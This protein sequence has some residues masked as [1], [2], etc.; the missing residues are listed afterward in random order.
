MTELRSAPDPAPTR[1]AWLPRLLRET[2]FRR[3]FA[4]QA[5]SQFG[6]QV[7]YLALP[8]MAVL[9]IGAGPA[10]M[11]YLTAA[12][13]IPN[14]LFSLHA[15][16]WVDRRPGKRQVM[17]VADLGRAVLL[18]AVPVLWWAG[19]LDLPHL[20]VIAFAIGTLSLFFE[21]AHGSLF[22]SLVARPDYIDANALINGTRAMSY[23]AG[24]SIGGVLVQVLTAPFALL[25]DVF[26]YLV[27]ALLLRRTTV[28]ERPVTP[29][30]SPGLG[31]GLRY[32]A[33]S[34]V[35][36]SILL[37]V[38]TLNLFNYIFAA[39]FVLYVTTQLGVSPGTLGAVIG[40]GAVGGL[41]GA[42]LTGRLSRRIG[43]GPTV[44]VGMVAF[45][46]PLVL[47]PA[48]EGSRP[49]VLGMLFAAEFCSALGVMVL[50]IAVGSLQTAATPPG[51]LALVHGAKRTVNYGVRPIGALIGGALGTALGVRPALWI[52]TVGALAGTLW[53]LFSPVRRMRELPPEP[54]EPAR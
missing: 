13:L 19:L 53:I 23:V 40:A 32:I 7:T 31:A 28:T 2:V 22:A 42:A 25:A 49:V 29:E 39:L 51:M 6:D 10:E 43:I 52:A 1:R 9:A 21:V 34:Q 54:D 5:V 4:A 45:P 14:L 18:A 24:P 26:S 27:S 37:G 20:Y 3:Y 35:L 17:I 30:G 48:A 8:L 47:V 12:G 11:G 44:I 33:R 38:T 46:A 15:G 36:R 50:D 16:A 41:L